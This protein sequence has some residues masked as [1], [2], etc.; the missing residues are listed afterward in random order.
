MNPN[1]N[2]VVCYTLDKNIKKI[3]AESWFTFIDNSYYF[4]TRYEDAP[5]NLFLA[6]AHLYKDS[7]VLGK[8]QLF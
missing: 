4:S 2:S 6:A 3:T 1:I 5:I 8:Y 7:W